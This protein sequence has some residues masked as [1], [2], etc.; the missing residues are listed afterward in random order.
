MITKPTWLLAVF[1]LL[2]TTAQAAK[3][4]A[5]GIS[6]SDKYK[7]SGLDAMGVRKKGPIKVYAVGKYGS[8]YLLKMNMGVSAEK[9]ASSTSQ[10][11]RPRCGDKDAVAKFESTLISG[12]P[13]GCS[14]G[15]SLAF[16]TGGGKL[17]IAIND[18]N[19]G[20]VGS[21]ALAKAFAGIYTDKNAVLDLK[22]VGGDDDADCEM[23]EGGGL[24]T[25]K[26][27][28]AVGA[29]LGWGIGKLLQ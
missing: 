3:E 19:A 21:K 9:M 22:P 8:T 6:F 2:T 4:P 17:T 10:A 20:N 5:T 27:C 15:T 23:T 7:G 18:K 28:A 11:L 1:L 24:V 25:P 14:K 16:G 29:A 13:N 12:L 26:R